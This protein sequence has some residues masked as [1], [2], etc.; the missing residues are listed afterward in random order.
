M[1]G[2]GPLQRVTLWVRDAD[3]SLA[4]YRDLLGLPVLEDKVVP[5]PYLGR[6]VGYEQAGL[7]IVHLGSGE[8]GWIGLY[9]L[10]DA[11]PV[12]VP[13]TPAPRQRLSPGQA[14]VV[15]QARGLDAIVASLDAAGYEFLLRP[16]AYVK[17]AASPAMPAGRYTETIFH[18]PD[19]FPV[20]LIEYTP[21]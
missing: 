19:G 2:A 7:R 12:P 1:S 11:Q 6:M 9:E 10:R 20:S 17:Q 3:A 18:D 4:L 8:S 21:A 16:Q 15:L 5:G 13:V 14:T